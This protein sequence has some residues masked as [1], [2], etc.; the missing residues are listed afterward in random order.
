MDPD[1]LEEAIKDRIAKTGRKPKAIV[2]VALYGMPAQ[3]EDA[4]GMEFPLLTYAAEQAETIASTY[5][6]RNPY[7]QTG[8]TVLLSEAANG[9]G[10]MTLKARVHVRGTHVIVRRCA[11]VD[12]R[13]NVSRH[14]FRFLG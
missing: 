8:Y 14:V 9:D 6:L 11:R 3:P 7:P 12:T 5:V 4:V 1:L 13:R 10:T 2:P